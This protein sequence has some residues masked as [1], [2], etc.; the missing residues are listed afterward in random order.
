M[1]GLVGLT[2]SEILA[3]S[4]LFFTAGY[5]T[6]ASTLAHLIYHLAMNPDYMDRLIAEIDKHYPDVSHLYS[7]TVLPVQI[8]VD[9]NLDHMDR[10]IANIDKNYR[11]VSLL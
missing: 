9:I 8:T 3:A 10:L 4:I 11:D 1:T 2:D 5:D 6:T 7:L